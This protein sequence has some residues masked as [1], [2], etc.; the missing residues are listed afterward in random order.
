MIF[1]MDKKPST[2]QQIKSFAVTFIVFWVIIIVVVTN[3][4]P[5]NS[6]YY[7]AILSGVIV[8]G[9]AFVFWTMN[10]LDK[11]IERKKEQL[12][13][14]GVKAK[15]TVVSIGQELKHGDYHFIIV[16]TVEVNPNGKKPFKAEFEAL[17]PLVAVPRVGDE[18][19]V[20]YDPQNPADIAVL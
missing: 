18:I 14:K 13:Q 20:V 5:E 1:C 9:L 2:K 3:F 8:S 4:V 11:S 19:E 12:L 10:R 16:L 7:E 17:V 6:P 15:A